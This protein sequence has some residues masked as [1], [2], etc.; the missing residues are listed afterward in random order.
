MLGNWGNDLIDLMRSSHTKKAHNKELLLMRFFFLFYSSLALML[1]LVLLQQHSNSTTT[2]I[3]SLG[4]ELVAMSA[5]V[6]LLYIFFLALIPL[7]L[8]LPQLSQSFCTF[9]LC[10]IWFLHFHANV[11]IIIRREWTHK[12]DHTHE[13]VYTLNAMDRDTER[14]RESVWG[15]NSTGKSVAK[16]VIESVR[17]IRIWWWRGKKN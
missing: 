5:I 11:D 17:L 9:N 4:V 8:S 2:T 3:I 12:L 7:S 15:K 16:N 10:N 6:L 1:L 13:Y 14:E